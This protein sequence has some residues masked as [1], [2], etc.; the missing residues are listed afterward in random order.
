[1]NTP[2]AAHRIERL[3]PFAWAAVAALIA[4]PFI[5]MQFTDQVAWTA[6]D[7]ALFASVLVGAGA[8]LEFAVVRSHNPA[9]RAGAALALL[10][11]AGLFLVTGAVGLIADE[12]HPGDLMYLG[13]LA[14]AAGGGVLAR[15]RPRGMALA[16]AATAA[17]QI[18]AGAAALAVGWGQPLE[19]AAATAGFAALWLGAAALFRKAA[20]S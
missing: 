11:G 12:G 1:M 5:A 10:T 13:V 4:A 9:F 2:F 17:A 16:L 18:L 3:R 7:F 6:F 14:L 20:Y 15:F 19:V 8:A